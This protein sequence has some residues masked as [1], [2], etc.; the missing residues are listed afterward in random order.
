MQTKLDLILK[1]LQD[2]KLR[3]EASKNKI[4]RRAL[5]MIVE[6]RENTNRRRDGEDDIIRRIKNISSHI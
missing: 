1:E 6:I 2:L 3:V 5:E 4:K